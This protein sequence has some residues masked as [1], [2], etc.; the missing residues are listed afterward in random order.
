MRTSNSRLDTVQRLC[1]DLVLNGE[2]SQEPR[3]RPLQTIPA[4]WCPIVIGIITH[5]WHHLVFNTCSQVSTAWQ[6]QGLLEELGFLGE[7]KRLG[8]VLAQRSGDSKEVC[9]PG[10]ILRSDICHGHS[11]KRAYQSMHAKTCVNAA[12]FHMNIWQYHTIPA[13]L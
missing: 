1:F 10:G 2:S 13:C 8:R 12:I 7:D 3:S 5:L 4:G 11:T 9:S 6:S